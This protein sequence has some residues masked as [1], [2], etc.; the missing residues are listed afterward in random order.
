MTETMT[1][2][3]LA[4]RAG[5]AG[6]TVRYYERRG[7][8]R[9]AGRTQANYRIYGPESVA[10]LQFIR[11]AQTSGL[12]LDD[13]RTLL[14]FSDGTVAPCEEVQAVIDSRLGHVR[15]QVKELRRVQRALERLH[16]ACGSS[17]R[18]GPCPAIEEFRGD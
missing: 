4:N 12:S 8:L 6:S 2:G 10:R 16:D 17:D 13:I 14:G 15:N 3:E 9:P 5:V 18:R 1:I 7:L 11:A